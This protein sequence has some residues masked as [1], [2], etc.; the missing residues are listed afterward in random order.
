MYL[1]VK[2]LLRFIKRRDEELN[3]E[4]YRRGHNGAHSKG[5]TSKRTFLSWNPDI[6]GFLPFLILVKSVC[7]ALN[8]ALNVSFAKIVGLT[9][10][11]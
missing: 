6:M 10:K 3:R 9:Y 7:F 1:N 5:C 4:K 8:F 11:N 2:K